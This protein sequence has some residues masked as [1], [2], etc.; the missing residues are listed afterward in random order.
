[1]ADDPEQLGQDDIEKLLQ[2]AQQADPP[3]EAPAEPPAA[4][5]VGLGQDEIEAMLNNPS[6]AAAA[7]PPQ[8]AV[9]EAVGQ[10]DIEGMFGNP[11]PT[12]AATP[13]PTP[14]ASKQRDAADERVAEEDLELL[15]DHAQQAIAS[16]DQPLDPAPADGAVPFRLSDFSGAP[17]S[18]EGATLELIRDV[19]LDVRIELGRANMHLEEVLKLHKGSVVP[20]DKLAGDPVDVYVNGRLIARGEVLVLNDNFCVRIAELIVGESAVA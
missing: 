14:P 1:M 19:E 4:E 13:Q 15:L 10:A 17:P 11:S 6:S 2:Q 9:T 3:A 12:A 7:P 8:E 20:L 5:L 18:A 16:V